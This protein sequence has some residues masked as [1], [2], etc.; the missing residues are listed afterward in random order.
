MLEGQKLKLLSK[1]FPQKF[2]AEEHDAYPLAVEPDQVLQGLRLFL[3]VLHIVK[4]SPGL[5][6]AHTAVRIGELA[7][8]H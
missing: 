4:D 3:A 7:E 6:P 8:L 5:H 1:V 2:L